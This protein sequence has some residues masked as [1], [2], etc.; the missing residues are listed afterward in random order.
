[1]KIFYSNMG[2][3]KGL[4]KYL[5]FPV[6]LLISYYGSKKVEKPLFCNDLFLD[7]GAYSAFRKNEIIDPLPYVNFIKEY[8]DNLF[9][10]AGI[11][12][13]GDP[14][15]TWENQKL[16]ESEDLKPLPCFHFGEPFKWLHRYVAKYQYI[17]LGGIVPIAQDKKQL[18][19]Y[20]DTCWE[21]IQKEN[22]NLKVHGF[23]LT[24]ENLM[25]RYPWYSVDSSS[26]H[27]MARYGGI[28]TPWGPLKV[29]T[30]VNPKELVW[31]TPTK[32]KIVKK[33]IKELSLP[34]SFKE[35]E[36]GSP[37]STIKRCAVNVSYF[38]QKFKNPG[39]PQKI[40]TNGFF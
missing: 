8:K 25:E 19:T 16:L 10:Y 1:M 33:W 40:I 3:A 18:F 9:V 11:D 37:V 2:S 7:S 30:S 39:K 6:D 29:N 36:E 23:G 28:Y 20:L 21:I 4:E 14:V 32:L 26:A 15:K 38:H 35:L 12:V 31:R 27:V 34:F 22:P 5:S 13:I 17:A 24:N